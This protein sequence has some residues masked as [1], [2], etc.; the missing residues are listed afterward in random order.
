MH[1]NGVFGFVV[2]Q[3]CRFI[4]SVVMGCL[5]TAYRKKEVFRQQETKANQLV[6]HINVATEWTWRLHSLA[7]KWSRL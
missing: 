4:S 6:R 2:L 7:D 1:L 5:K 3:N